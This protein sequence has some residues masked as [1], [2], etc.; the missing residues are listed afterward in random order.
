MRENFM[1]A[2]LGDDLHF[3]SITPIDRL[4]IPSETSPD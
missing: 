2:S 4:S 3:D 1:K